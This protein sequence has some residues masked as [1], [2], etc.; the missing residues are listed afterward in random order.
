MIPVEPTIIESAPVGVAYGPYFHHRHHRHHPRHHFGHHPGGHHPRHHVGHHR[1]HH[2]GHLAWRASSAGMLLA[3]IMGIIRMRSWTVHMI[4]QGWLRPPFA[5]V[6]AGPLISKKD[7]HFY[8]DLRHPDSACIIF[9]TK[10]LRANLNDLTQLVRVHSEKFD[11]A[12]KQEKCE[13][14][15]RFQ[16]CDGITLI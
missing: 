11:R 9:F 12:N 10:G 13:L 8:R 16:N 5:F 4:R 6:S 1:G 14:N 15:G 3:G 2:S 7:R